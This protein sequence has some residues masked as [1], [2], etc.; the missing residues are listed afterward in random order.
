MRTGQQYLDS[1]ADDRA[2]FVHGERVAD[3][4]RHP[5]FRGITGTMA[6]L[7]DFAADPANAM[8][9]VAPETGRPA[10]RTF[11]IPRSQDDLKTRRVAITAWA[12][13]TGGLLGRGP[14]H[15]AGF[16]AGFASAPDVFARGRQAF[17]DN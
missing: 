12:E 15:V 2:V 11:M 5:A 1:L 13:Q 3:I 14:D 16:L 9:F 10:N 4:R 7:Y 6:G 17:A 8:Q